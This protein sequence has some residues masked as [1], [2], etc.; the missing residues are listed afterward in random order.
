[1]LQRHRS[2][3]DGSPERQ[4]GVSISAAE[5]AVICIASVPLNDD[6]WRPLAEGELL[7]VRGGD[8][9]ATHTAGAA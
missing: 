1:M 8:L 9:F 5:R 2:P 3:V 4:G 6:A 7:A